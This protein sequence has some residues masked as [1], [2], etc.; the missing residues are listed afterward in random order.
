MKY[1]VLP[2]LKDYIF[3]DIPC[4]KGDGTKIDPTAISLIVYEDSGADSSTA[5]TQITGS[6]FTPAKQNSKTGW[7]GQWIAKSAFTAGNYYLFLWEATIDGIATHWTERYLAT[8]KSWL[9]LTSTGG[10]EV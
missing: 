10:Y 1:L 2:I 3:F 7:Y 8:S 4:N 5:T 9:S 6:P